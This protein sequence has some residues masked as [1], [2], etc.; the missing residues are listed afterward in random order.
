MAVAT[1]SSGQDLECEVVVDGQV[2]KENKKSRSKCPGVRVIHGRIYD[3]D[4]GKT[5]HQC[6]QK[7]R[8][9]AAECKILKGN[10]QCTIKYCH[11]CLMNRYGEKAE[12]V[13]LLDNWTCPKCRGICNCSF[14][15]KKRGHKPTGILVHTA[16]ENGFSSVS[17]LLQIKGPENFACDRFPNNTGA[18]LNK[19][20][21][22]KESIIASPRKL[23][24]ENSLD[25]KCDSH[26]PKSSPVSNK[27]KHKKAKSEGLHDV[28]SL[29]DS[30]RKK[31]RFTE[32]VLTNKMKI[33]GKDEDSLV[34]TCKSKI[35]FKDIPKKEVKKNDKVEGV[36][37]VGKKFKKQSQDVSKKEVINV[38]AESENEN[39]QPQISRNVVCLIANEKRDT[40]N[41]KSIGVPGGV[42]C[43]VDKGTIELQSKQ[44]EDD[45][46]LPSGTCLTNV[47]GIELPHEDA[48]HALQFFEFCAAFAEV[49][50]LRKGQAEAVIR[51]IIFGRKARR[52]HS[53]LLVQFQIKL[54]SL[55]L[56]DMGEESPTL[57]TANGQTSWLKAFGKCVSDRKFMSKEFP[58]DCF[59]R[60]NERYDM[61]NTSEK[62]K[63]LNF[64]C[65]EALNTKDL[66]SWIDDRNSKFVEKEKEA[67]EKVLAAKDKEKNL[68]QK[69]HDEVAKAIIAKSGAPFSVSEHEAIV[70]QIKKEAA[71]AHVEMMAAVG[72]VPK[73]R[74]RS[75]AV[76]T[77]PILLDVNGHA[78]WRLKGYNGQSDILLQDMG[79]WTVAAPEEKWFVYDAEQK[80]GVEKYISSL[81]TKRLRAQ[82]V[83]GRPSYADSE[84]NL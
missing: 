35:E 43:N 78:F 9:F 41:C 84:T 11:K 65:D 58:S 67:K 60:G 19:P 33:N 71:Q 8:D 32:E 77:D 72:M 6:R 42:K 20:A 27:K 17:E 39:F 69:V 51:E 14:C 57:S 1:S 12:E 40:G 66:R 34:K 82:K 7:T 38:K 15:M 4:N 46:Q 37:A 13:A 48:G 53:S 59:D 44:T 62:F 54:L 21:S 31:P 28:N 29:R 80:Q 10:K 23:G 56:E 74:Q 5:C 83:A 73:K 25:G 70:S 50:D 63:L 81:R 22:A 52:S 75:D 45:I 16:K 68:K 3:S 24:K 61:L 79:N 55:I 76:R 18:S 49:L 2:K 47:A 26:S 36:I 64:L 30:S